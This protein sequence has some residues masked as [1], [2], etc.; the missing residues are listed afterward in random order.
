M[1]VGKMPRADILRKCIIVFEGLRRYASKG[2]AGL[3]AEKGAEDS[4]T[5]DDMIVQGLKEWLREIEAG[6]TGNRQPETFYGTALKQ[7]Q[8]DIINNGP[9]ER[10]TF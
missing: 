7:W 1:T 6:G 9:P 2:N 10:M 4:F 8:E 3:E 5:L